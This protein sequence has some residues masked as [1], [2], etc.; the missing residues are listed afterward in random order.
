MRIY[1]EA[2]RMAQLGAKHAVDV[3]AFH[4]RVVKYFF[5]QTAANVVVCRAALCTDGSSAG[6]PPVTVL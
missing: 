2:E 6:G 5:F 1:F 4:S 3:G